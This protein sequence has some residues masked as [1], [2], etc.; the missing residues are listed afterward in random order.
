MRKNIAR[1]TGVAVGQAGQLDLDD[2]RQRFPPDPA[3]LQLAQTVLRHDLRPSEIK[4][5]R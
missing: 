2:A 4:L 3:P 5:V 1:I